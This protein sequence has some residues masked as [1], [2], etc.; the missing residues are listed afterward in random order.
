MPEIATTNVERTCLQ[1]LADLE[2][3]E[4]PWLD[5]MATEDSETTGVAMRLLLAH[6]TWNNKRLLGAMVLDRLDVEMATTRWD[7]HRD[8]HGL[9]MSTGM[10][11]DP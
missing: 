7:I 8:M 2:R 10:T 1:G 3:L 4:W 6:L 9:G 5:D 11:T